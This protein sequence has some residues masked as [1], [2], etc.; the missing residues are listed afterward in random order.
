VTRKNDRQSSRRLATILIL[1]L[2]SANVVRAAD[3]NAAET[4]MPPTANPA[5]CA[6]AVA[7]KDVIF[8]GEPR[9]MTT[10][11]LPPHCEVRGAAAGK[12]RFVM[13]LPEVTGPQIT[14]QVGK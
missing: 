11:N 5:S 6:A 10:D 14:G 8:D 12:I 9:W 3:S 1:A 4:S 7:P 13:R 2:L